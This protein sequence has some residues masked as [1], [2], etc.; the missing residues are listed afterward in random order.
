MGG[1][2][3]AAG[4]ADRRPHHLRDQ[5]AGGLR[6][7]GAG[8]RGDR[9]AEPAGSTTRCPPDPTRPVRH[10]RRGPVGRRPRPG[11]HGH[12]GRRQ[13]RLA[14]ARPDRRRRARPAVVLPAR[15]APR[16]A[17]AR[18]RCCR[19]A[20]FRNRTSNL[21]LVTQNAQWLMLMGVSFVGRGLPA[22]RAR[23]RRDPDRRD[24]HRGHRRPARCPRWPPSASPSGAPQRTLILAG[25]VVTIAASACCSP[26]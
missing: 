17:R 13:Q 1:I 3:A 18:S 24:L 19:P 12:P 26:W 2:G 9:R 6:L 25:F 23:L 15:C 10:R 22:G 11:R 4:P 7:P 8:H 21:G 5:L 20:L 14:D 16:S